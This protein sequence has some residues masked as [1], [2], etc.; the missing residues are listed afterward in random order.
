MKTFLRLLGFSRPYHHY[1]PEYLVYILLFTLFSLLNFT[2]II[3]L[4]DVLFNTN[5]HLVTRIPAFSFSVSF[6]KDLFYYELTYY[7]QTS[8][9]FGVL[10]FVCVILFLF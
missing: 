1:V 8:G 5:E 7:I 4:L 6:F 2:M 3:P 9:K 10:I